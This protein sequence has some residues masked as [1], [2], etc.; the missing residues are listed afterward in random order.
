MSSGGHDSQ[1]GMFFPAAE[2]RH[3]DPLDPMSPWRRRGSGVRRYRGPAFVVALVF[4]LAILAFII[5]VAIQVFHA[6]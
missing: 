5:F 6:H 4:R 2:H 3:H 1:P